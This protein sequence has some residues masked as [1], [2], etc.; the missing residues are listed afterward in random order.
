MTAASDYVAP[1]PAVLRGVPELLVFLKLPE[2][3]VS[4]WLAT[5]TASIPA[6]PHLQ[7]GGT[8]LFYTAQVLTWLSQYHGYGGEMRPVGQRPVTARVRRA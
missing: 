6:L 4:T 2:E 5:G 8:R 1:L 3:F 7:V